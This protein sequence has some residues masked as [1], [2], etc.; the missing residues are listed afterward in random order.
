MP[1]ARRNHRQHRSK[2]PSRPA[3]RF[4]GVAVRAQG[5]HLRRIVRGRPG[6][7]RGCGRSPGSGHRCRS[8]LGCRR[9]S[10]GFRARPR[11]V[12]GLYVP[13][14]GPNGLGWADVLLARVLSFPDQNTSTLLHSRRYSAARA[15][16]A[17]SAGPPDCEPDR[18]SSLSSAVGSAS[19]KYVCIKARTAAARASGESRTR[20]LD[21]CRNRFLRP[22]LVERALRYRAAMRIRDCS[23]ICVEF[24]QA[25][26]V[27]GGR[28]VVD[29]GGLSRPPVTLDQRGE[30]LL[31]RLPGG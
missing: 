15:L 24:P 7:D 8:G 11:C 19:A 3:P 2:V 9:C 14:I 17:A 12:A 21:R 4:D 20:L 28:W 26:V 27:Q 25:R 18:P 13:C 1:V 29:P 31:R 23:G 6:R 22:M 5:D 10:P 16:K 30:L